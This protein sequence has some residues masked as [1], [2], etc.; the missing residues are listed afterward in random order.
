[1]EGE[2]EAARTG[3]TDAGVGNVTFSIER[4][5]QIK[6]GNKPHKVTVAVVEFVPRFQYFATPEQEERV[7]LHVR[8]TNDSAYKL[9]ASSK[10]SVFFNESFV[11]TTRIVDTSPGEEISTFLGHDGAVKVEHRR[12]T[13]KDTEQTGFMSA[14]TRSTTYGSLVIVSNT[15]EIP[16]SVKIVS[17]MPRSEVEQIVVHLEKPSLRELVDEKDAGGENVTMQNPVTNNIVWIRQLA[18]GQKL[19][20]PI[21]YTVKWPIDKTITISDACGW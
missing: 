12:I 4:K 5:V 20:L 18:A 21:Q 16:V 3:V 17:L 13:S 1:M 2:Y 8:A 7:Y 19:E 6:A 10:V 11:T 14:K 15:K 9:L